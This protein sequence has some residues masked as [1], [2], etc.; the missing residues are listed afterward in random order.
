MNES[1]DERARTDT[2]ER[3]GIGWGWPF[4][5]TIGLGGFAIM[6][7]IIA[8]KIVVPFDQ[9]HIRQRSLD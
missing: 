2:A 6:T 1:V 3:T 8:S 5:A 9:P 4:L 7:W